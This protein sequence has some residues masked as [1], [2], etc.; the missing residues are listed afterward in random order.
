MSKYIAAFDYSYTSPS[1]CLLDVNNPSFENSIFYVLNDKKEKVFRNINIHEHRIIFKSEIER[2]SLISD[3]FIEKM[4]GYT[5]FDENVWI[6]GYSFQ[7]TGRT[8][9]IGENT[10]LLKHKLE[11]NGF[12]YQVVPPTVVKK[13]LTG[14]G[15]ASKIQMVDAVLP[16]VP[17]NVSSEFKNLYKSPFTD[18]CDSYAIAKYAL[19]K[20]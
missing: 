16:E 5:F 8:F 12:S 11:Q 15:N 19:S 14:K 3:F 13:H 20:M 1:L 10:A 6:E 7:S 9:Q 4:K 17:K 18:I 2:F